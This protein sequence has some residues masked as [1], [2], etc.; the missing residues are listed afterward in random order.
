MKK[1]H[2]VNIGGIIFQV[3]EDAYEKL[4]QYMAKLHRHFSD[5]EGKEEIIADIEQR[6][7]EMLVTRLGETN[8]IVNLPVIEDI[9]RILGDP[10]DFGDQPQEAATSRRNY[11]RRLYRDPDDKILGGVAGGIGSYFNFDPLWARIAFVV[12]TIFG[13]SGIL[14]YLIMWVLIPE[15]RTTAERLEM[16]GEEINI[17]NIER[18]IKEEMNDI[19]NRFGKWK[20]D[21]Y[22]K[23]KDSAGRVIESAGDVFITL[24]T[25]FV[26]IVAGIIGFAIFVTAV[27][28]LLAILVPGFTFQGFPVW[29]DLTF[30]ELIYAFTGNESNALLIMI[31]LV[32]I[33]VLPLLAFLWGGIKLLFGIR[34][35]VKILGISMTAIWFLS[36]MACAALSVGTIRDFS[37]RGVVIQQVRLNASPSDT[38]VIGMKPDAHDYWNPDEYD[39]YEDDG[40]AAMLRHYNHQNGH[41]VTGYPSV[42]FRESSGDSMYVSVMKRSRGKNYRIAEQRATDI[43]Y[44]FS[45]DSTTLMLDPLFFSTPQTPFRHQQVKVNIYLP[46]G[47]LFKLDPEMQRRAGSVTNFE[48]LWDEKLPAG[49]LKLK[50][51]KI[52]S[53]Q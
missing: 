20:Q 30:Q 27:A 52:I 47:T 41:V 24:I 39:L 38:L 13:G 11:R 23:K 12:L 9:I 6:I 19:R 8:R 15:A 48:P 31:C 53:A 49:F 51:G 34:E 50:D 29:N 4:E 25:V 32:V 36:V 14:I 21:G 35:R 18:S 28:I 26:R 17:N 7:S 3:D 33:V 42:E 5:T 46:A 45:A 2:S 37:K 40:F 10:T 16:R 44:G 22:R 1:S 43:R